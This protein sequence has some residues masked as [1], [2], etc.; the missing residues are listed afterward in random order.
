MT[1]VLVESAHQV[2]LVSMVLC[3][4]VGTAS[5]AEE[6]SGVLRLML[7]MLRRGAGAMSSQDIERALDRLGAEMAVDVSSS[8]VGI[9]AQVVKRNFEKF[10]DLLKTLLSSPTF[11]EDEF[12]RLVRETTAEIIEARDN[13]RVVAQKAFQ[14]SFFQGHPYGRNAGGTVTTISR[15][16]RED[17]VHAYKTHVVQENLVLGFAGD[18]TQEEAE[19]AT[20]TLV[21]NLPRGEAQDDRTSEPA[22]K[23]GRH[24][25]F[26]DKP[27]RSQTQIL[28][29]GMGTSARDADHVPLTVANAVFGGTFTSR[30][31]REVR[32]K[33]GW[34]YGAS[35]RLSIDRQRQAF[36]MWTFP[37]AN[38]AGPCI[39]LEL[40]L[41]E[42]FVEKGITPSEARF[43]KKYLERSYAFDV[44]TA[45]KRLHQALDVALL[46]LPHDY[47]SAHVE[48]VRRVTEQEANRAVLTRMHPDHLL[49][50]VV[51]TKETTLESVTKCISGL[52]S[53]TVIP[54]DAE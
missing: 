52:A 14:R 7:R 36:V 3:L 34:S 39:E 44:D 19:R 15:M 29:G 41:L 49:V 21:S 35:S 47:Y 13:D 31:M 2:P 17:L 24:L 54:F 12:G 51:G 32:S 27:E 25:V 38:D 28:I 10:V 22:E 23:P 16:G 18:I 48:R 6:K 26:V 42:A 8:T 33:R 37:A 1:K 9:H 20:H 5:E 43:A 46:D 4:R 11:P 45:S 53:T 30:L 50:V 40:S